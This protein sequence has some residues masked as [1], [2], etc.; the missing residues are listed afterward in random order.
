MSDYLN[1]EDFLEPINKDMISEDAGYKDNQIGSVIDAY[2]EGFPEL[3]IADIVILGCGE[4]RGAGLM[5]RSDAADEVRK[6][7]Y[8]LFYWHTDVKLADVGNLRIG[9]NVND[10]YAALDRKSVV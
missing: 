7:F 2:E 5:T 9:N 4:Q 10:T 6:E 1:I 3:E 8:K